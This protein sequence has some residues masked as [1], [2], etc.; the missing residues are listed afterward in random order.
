MKI[1][2]EIIGAIA[3]IINFLI[4]QQKKRK[5]VLK[6]KLI[7]DISW[8]MHYGFIGAFS[9]MAVA[10]VGTARETTF[11]LTEDKK[12]KRKYFLIV[13]A[14]ISIVASS[15]TMKDIKE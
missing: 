3:I 2:G 5:N 12:D 14:I 9:G 6:V 1:A 10:T 8:A 7:S 15:L 4:Y 11:L 13:F